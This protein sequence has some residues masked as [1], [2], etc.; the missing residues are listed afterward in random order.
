MTTDPTYSPGDWVITRYGGRS[1]TT[2]M[3]VR[4]VAPSRSGRPG[5]IMDRPW[6]NGNPRAAHTPESWIERRA[7][8][9]EVAAAQMAGD[10]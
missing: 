6:N 9:E 2:R 8:P 3:A 10:L 5:W 4:L 1:G 7:T